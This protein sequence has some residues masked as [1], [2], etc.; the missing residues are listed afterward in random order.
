MNQHLRHTGALIIA[1]LL[2]WAA[3]PAAAQSVQ[4]QNQE[5]L[6]ELKAIHQLLDTLVSRLSAPSPAAGA[7][8]PDNRVRLTDLTGFSL[9]R[10]DAPLTMVE[11]TDL[12]CPFCRQ[13]H[14][15][16]FDQLKK[17]YIDTGK[18]RYI[19]RDFPIDQ[20]HPLATSAARVGRCAADQGKFWEMRH[21]ILANNA[22]LTTARFQ[23]FAKELQLDMPTFTACVANPAAHDA[24]LRKDA[25]EAAKVGVSGTPSFV[26]GP[27]GADGL[28]GYLLVGAQPYPTF[29][30]GLKE[31]LAKIPAK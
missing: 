20:L 12:Q 3:A 8:R 14:V 30:A 23:D 26:V 4:Q 11:F 1:A 15:T 13:F 10:A 7:G 5:I 2:V 6:T 18:L 29:D 21:L 27:T 19:S 17:D 24:E 25:A 31:L 28:D 9:G 16:A 22:S